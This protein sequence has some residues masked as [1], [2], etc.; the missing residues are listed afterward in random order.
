MRLFLSLALL[1]FLPVTLVR[2]SDFGDLAAPV[3]ANSC[4]LAN[5][6]TRDGQDYSGSAGTTFDGQYPTRATRE[7]CL[8][9]CEASERVRVEEK[10]EIYGLRVACFYGE[11]RLFEREYMQEMLIPS[12]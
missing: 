2:A 3:E 12:T 11:D 1:F 6:Y 4:R 9:A 10:P 8:E 7:E 5:M